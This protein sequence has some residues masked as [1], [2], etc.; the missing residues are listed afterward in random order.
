MSDAARSLER[1]DGYPGSMRPPGFPFFAAVV[2]RTTTESLLALRVAQIALSLV[3]MWFFF[4][5][6]RRRFGARP[7]LISSAI[8]AF[9]PTLIHYTHFLWAENLVTTLLLAALWALDRWDASARQTWIVVAGLVLGALTLTREMAVYFVPFVV[10]WVFGRDP[11]RSTVDRITDVVVLTVVV[12][13]VVLPWTARNYALHHRFVLVGTLQWFAIATGNLLPESNWIFGRGPVRPFEIAYFEIH[14]E[15]DRE[16]FARDV[17][18]TA[19]RREQPAWIVKKIIRNVYLLFTPIETQLTRFLQRRWLAAGSE[20]L[21]RRL[22][23]FEAAFYVVSLVVGVAALCLVPDARLKFLVVA[24]LL[25]FVGIYIVATGHHRYRVPLLPLFALY[26]GPYVCGYS[27][28][29]RTGWTRRVTAV[30]SVVLVAAVCF[31]GFVLDPDS[32]NRALAFPRASR[33]A[34]R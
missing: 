31:A 19:I 27:A 28:R 29:D 14:N 17:A 32:P 16:A 25:L 20:L 3:G 5:L 4:D 9:H 7:A 22:A 13:A 2:F 33:Q 1:G 34:G 21:A 26:V 11:R 18:L 10:A 24:L 23:L 15:L 12:A 30:V 8:V 6:L